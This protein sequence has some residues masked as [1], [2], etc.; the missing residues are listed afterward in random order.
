MTTIPSAA[1]ILARGGDLGAFVEVLVGGVVLLFLLVLTVV[2]IAG[3]WMVFTKAGR[4]GWVALIPLYN[5]YVVLKIAG[6]PGWWLLLLFIPVAG[7]IIWAVV[8]IDVAR[9]FG[10][11]ASYGLLLLFLLGGIG[12]LILGFGS[13]PYRNPVPV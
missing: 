12:F 7:S 11:D 10:K 5:A 13:A 4:P 2:Y 8:C 9:H 1:I 3:F 6:R